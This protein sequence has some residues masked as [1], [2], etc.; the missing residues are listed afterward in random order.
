MDADA[1]RH[2]FA[3]QSLDRCLNGKT[4]AAGANRVVFLRRGRAEQCHDPIALDL[5]DRA[6]E[7]AD[8]LLH[9]FNCGCEALGCLFRV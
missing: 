9:R 7:A 6:F 2:F 5:D 8:S 4:R 1:H 3:G